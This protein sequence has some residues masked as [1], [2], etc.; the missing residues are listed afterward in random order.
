MVGDVEQ[1][2]R[3]VI[4]MALDDLGARGFE[5]QARLDVIEFARDS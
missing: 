2:L 4:E 1:R 3:G 5:A